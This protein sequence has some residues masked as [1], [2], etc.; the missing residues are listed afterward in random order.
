[1]FIN[2]A[3][4]LRENVCLGVTPGYKDECIGTGERGVV[5]YN[6]RLGAAHAK[7]WSK[8]VFLQNLQQIFFFFFAFFSAFQHQNVENAFH[9]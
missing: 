2:C 3:T 9:T 5:Y 4:Q 6:Q 7:C 8:Y 1:M